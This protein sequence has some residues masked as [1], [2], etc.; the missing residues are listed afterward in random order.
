MLLGQLSCSA[1]AGGGGSDG[2]AQT[3]GVSESAP[4]SRCGQRPA[5][6]RK[7]WYHSC[8]AE[9]VQEPIRFSIRSATSQLFFLC[10]M[11]FPKLLPT[12][13]TLIASLTWN[14]S[15]IRSPLSKIWH[16]NK[17]ACSESSPVQSSGSVSTTCLRKGR[18][19]RFESNSAATSDGSAQKLGN[20]VRRNSEWIAT[21]L[22]SQIGRKWN[23]IFESH[24]VTSVDR[25][26]FDFRF[27]DFLRSS[28]VNIHL[29]CY[30]PTIHNS[31]S[32]ICPKFQVISSHFFKVDELLDE[33]WATQYRPRMY[34]KTN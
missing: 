30:W 7:T 10:D 26:S 6:L 2:Q 14:L 28:F 29:L 9:S 33:H 25:T 27:E 18:L 12:K 15:I 20:D 5:R 11:K 8:D 13:A 4:G 22:C 21:K 31:I 1:C 16:R 3:Q 34:Q 23:A 19:L 24:G 17:T 32:K